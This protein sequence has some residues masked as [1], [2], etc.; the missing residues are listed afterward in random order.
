MQPGVRNLGAPK[1]TPC[2]LGMEVFTPETIVPNV[3]RMHG[4]KHRQLYANMPHGN[5]FG[6]GTRRGPGEGDVWNDAGGRF[7]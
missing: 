6:F 5:M 1:I 3:S 7:R 4:Q 2:P